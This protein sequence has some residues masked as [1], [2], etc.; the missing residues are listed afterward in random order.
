MMS[1]RWITGR[2]DGDIDHAS[3]EE[4]YPMFSFI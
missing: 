3:S 4:S 2:N 1:R